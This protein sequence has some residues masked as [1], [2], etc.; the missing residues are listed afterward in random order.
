MSGLK[1][2]H[3]REKGGW[4]GA[5]ECLEAVPVGVHRAGPELAKLGRGDNRWLKSQE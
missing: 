5:G 4:T 3:Q 1:K 2:Y